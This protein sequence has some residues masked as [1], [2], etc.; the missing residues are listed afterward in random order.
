MSMKSTEI[1]LFGQA[2]KQQ[3]SNFEPWKPWKCNKLWGQG[4]E[5]SCL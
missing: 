2:G 1:C 3:L 4:P 5:P